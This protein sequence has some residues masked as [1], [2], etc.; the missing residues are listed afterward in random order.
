MAHFTLLNQKIL[1][2]YNFLLPYLDRIEATAN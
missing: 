2:A 1:L